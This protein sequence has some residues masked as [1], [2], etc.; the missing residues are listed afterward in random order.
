MKPK[1]TFNVQG[2]LHVLSRFGSGIH[3]GIFFTVEAAGSV[4]RNSRCL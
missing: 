3:S 1:T 2:K 4:V